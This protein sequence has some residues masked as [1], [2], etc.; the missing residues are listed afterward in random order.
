V[1]AGGAV[2]ARGVGQTVQIGLPGSAG[3]AG[4]RTRVRVSA[5]LTCLARS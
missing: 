5:A 2:L 3:R 4:D 1:L